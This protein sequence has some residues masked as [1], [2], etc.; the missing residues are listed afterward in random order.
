MAAALQTL[1]VRIERT[2]EELRATWAT[3]GNIVGEDGT[4]RV[5]QAPQANPPLLQQHYQIHN[6]TDDS[7]DEEVAGFFGRNPNRR[8][9]QQY[10][11]HEF[12]LKADLLSFNGSL[13]IEG[14]LDCVAE[15][16]RFFEYAE[17]PKAKQVKLVA[18]LLKGGVSS[19]WEQVQT[20]RGRL[21]KQSVR[22][23]PKMKRMLTAIFLPPDYEQFLFHQYQ[24]LTQ[25]QKSVNEYTADFLRL[26]SRNNLMETEGQQWPDMCMGFK[27]ND[28]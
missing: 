6:N 9:Q 5:A 23:W 26:S 11:E 4:G 15:V 8:A 27:A 28:P 24:T 25:G 14:F 3:M 20:Q 12:R 1:S 7:S 18:Y 22:L 2:E 10:R 19:R 17:I 21:G 16:E 13:N